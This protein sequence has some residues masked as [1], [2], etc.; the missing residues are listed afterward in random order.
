MGEFAQHPIHSM[1]RAGIAI[2][3]VQTVDFLLTRPRGRRRF[4]WDADLAALA[5][6]SEAAKNLTGSSEVT[7]EGIASLVANASAT[8]IIVTRHNVVVKDAAHGKEVME[9]AG[10]AWDRKLQGWH[11]P[12]AA[13]LR[14]LRAH[15]ITDAS[16]AAVSVPP[17]APLRCFDFA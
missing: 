17:Q 15:S 14:F 12:C 9:K 11:M 6:P 7:A 8:S 2:R 5:L 13:A 16:P 1:F 10:F 3:S 4:V